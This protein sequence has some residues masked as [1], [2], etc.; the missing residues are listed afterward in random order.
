M[1]AMP[2]RFFRVTSLI[3]NGVNSAVIALL[4][5]VGRG[6]TVGPHDLDVVLDF[7]FVL[8]NVHAG[9]ARKSDLNRGKRPALAHLTR[10]CWIGRS[11]FG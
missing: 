9:C 2:M 6:P 4:S 5:K 10:I 7:F 8:H 3:F 11:G 1:G